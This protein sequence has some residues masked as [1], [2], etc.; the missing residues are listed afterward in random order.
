MS[1]KYTDAQKKATYKYLKSMDRIDLKLP[2]GS[3]D[4]IKQ[5]VAS[6]EESVNAFIG[7]A[8]NETMVRD[9]NLDSTKNSS[10]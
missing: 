3:K 6:T 8:I 4:K 5:H 2:K 7:R 9:N 1:E 10:N